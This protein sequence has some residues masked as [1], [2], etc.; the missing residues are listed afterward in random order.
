MKVQEVD[1]LPVVVCLNFLI[2][3]P[4]CAPC[5]SLTTGD[6]GQLL[7][8]DLTGPLPTPRS[9]SRSTKNAS[10]PAYALSPPATPA[11]NR[12]P[13]PVKAVDI[14]PTKAWTADSEVNNLAFTDKGDWVGAVS[15]QKLS[16]LQM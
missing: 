15:G 14:L 7:M 3:T 11:T 12:T 5:E 6:D 13:S 9:E 4:F 16:V 8:Y 2:S 10:S 1:G